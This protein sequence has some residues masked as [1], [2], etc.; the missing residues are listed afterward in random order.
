[1]KVEYT[2]V[3]E[4]D[5]SVIALA[6]QTGEKVATIVSMINQQRYRTAYNRINAERA[7]VI[8]RLIKEH[9]ELVKEVEGGTK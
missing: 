4:S 7:K 6:K 3:A 9:P 1:M 2:K 5:T 8:R